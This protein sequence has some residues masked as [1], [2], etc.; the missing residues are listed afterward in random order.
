MAASSFPFKAMGGMAELRID[1]LDPA[2]ARA[3][4]QA[5]IDEIVRIETKFSRYLPGSIVARIN[6]GA[7]GDWIDCDEE[8]LAL[9]GFADAL[10]ESSG[11]LFDISSGVLRRAWDFTKPRRPA[12]GQLSSLCA[13]IGWQR[14]ERKESAVR[15]PAAGME[16][17]FGGFGKE[18]AADRAAASLANQGARH[19]FVNLAGDVSTTGPK[20][21]GQPWRIG[22]AH[23]RR[24]G[25]LLATVPLG[26]G[27]LATSGDYER[28]FEQDGKRYCH[29]LDPR[30]GEP[31]SC[32]QS[33][34]V[35]APR[36]IAAGA[37]AT[38]AM[39][40]QADALAFLRQ[41]GVGFLAVDQQGNIHQHEQ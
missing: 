17:D 20:A 4:A 23:P 8:T 37:C 32:W 41:A 25:A 3:L 26:G 19:A 13:L 2:K 30:N 5:A 39:L 11:G 1:G 9:F 16:I 18:Y 34:S 15:L 14:V 33:V 10:F 28:Y 38:I 40:K 24:P 12:P 21:D 27:A 22:I 31:V 35:M 6:A 36:A 7:G 29:V